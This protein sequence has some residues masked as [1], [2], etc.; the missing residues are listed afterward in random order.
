MGLS[1]SL[2]EKMIGAASSAIP[3]IAPSTT[4][5]AISHEWFTLRRGSVLLARWRRK[6]RTVAQGR[7]ADSSAGF[8]GGALAE[9]GEI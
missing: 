1:A 3:A 5:D 9:D 7:D 4:S 8:L 6:L 2:K